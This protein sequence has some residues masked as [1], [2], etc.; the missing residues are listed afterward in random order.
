MARAEWTSTAEDELTEIA[1]WIAVEAGRP[2]TAR[3]I[4]EEIQQK[5]DFY[6]ANPKLGQR[7]PDFPD[8]WLYFRHKRWIVVY[9]PKN[10]GVDILRVVDA[11]RDFP[12]LFP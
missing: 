3:S 9:R 1:Y 6:A 10:D 11:S 2:G 12:R 4:V 5:A 7:H 8:G